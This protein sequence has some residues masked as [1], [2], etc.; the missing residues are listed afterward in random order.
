MSNPLS[1]SGSMSSIKTVSPLP[2]TVFGS[3]FSFFPSSITGWKKSSIT[4]VSWFSFLFMFLLSLGH[5]GGIPCSGR[6][7]LSFSLGQRA[8]GASVF[9]TVV[10][11]V[12][13]E[14]VVGSIVV[15]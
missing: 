14:V 7:K 5:I 2:S 1:K 12:V 6:F 9:T 11:D 13:D 10:S 15:R 3:D 4:S 8:G